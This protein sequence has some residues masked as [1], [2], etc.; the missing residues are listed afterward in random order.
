MDAPDFHLS[1]EPIGVFFC[2]QKFPYEAQR[3]GNLIDDGKTGVVRLRPGRNFEQALR[4]IESFTRLWLI[5]GFDRNRNWK[6]VVRPP[7][8][9]APRV[10]VFASRSPYRPN[11][12][13]L[14]C[15]ELL[16]VS[17][18]ELTVRGFDLLDASPIYDIKPY[19][20]YA[21]SFP[22]AGGGWTDR[23][24]K[25]SRLYTIEIENRAREK[26]E[27]L[28]QNAGVDLERF[29]NVQLR[30]HPDDASRKRLSRPNPNSRERTLAYRT[31][32]IDLRLPPEFAS[33]ARETADATDEPILIGDVRSAYTPA[34]LAN[35]ATPDRYE[36]L[37]IHRRFTRHFVNF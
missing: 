24:E 32:R 13:G 11:P 30:E 26:I 27:W 1:L 34:E 7:R 35:S 23:L 31:Y 12:L 4:E 5:Y 2:A 3:Q 6:P 22:E 33:E 19:L 36:D 18:L 21:D 17:G 16:N 25:K 28:K 10:G 20:P 29:L 14:S 8:A 37:D 15:V 9:D